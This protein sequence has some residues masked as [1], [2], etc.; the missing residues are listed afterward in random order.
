M[1]GNLERRQTQKS[2]NIGKQG[3]PETPACIDTLDCLR[4]AMTAMP[5]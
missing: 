1:A 4:Y 3:N 5:N 2:L